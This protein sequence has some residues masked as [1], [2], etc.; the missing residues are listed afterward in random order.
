MPGKLFINYRRQDEPG[1]TQALFLLL[2]AEFGR[3]QL[4]MD[5]Q[6][7]IE[8]GHDFTRVLGARVAACDVVLAVIG[9]RWLEAQDD[10]SRRRL[11]NPDD[12]VRIELTS[13]LSLDKRVIP[14]LVNDAEMPRAQ[15]LPDSLKRISDCQAVNITHERFRPDVQ[16]LV[17]KIRSAFE[18]EAKRNR[19]V[20]L[21]IAALTE[22]WQ[23]ELNSKL[24]QALQTAHLSCNILAPSKNHKL[25]EERF[26]QR[27]VLADADN[28]MGGLAIISGWPDEQIKEL[29]NFADQFQRPVVFIDQN[30]PISEKEIPK[31]V[32]F[33]S[34]RD[35]AGGL[36]AAEAVLQLADQRAVRRILVIAGFAKPNRHETFKQAIRSKLGFDPD[37]SKRGDFNR[38]TS[39]HVV[40]EFLVNGLNENKPFDV[41]FCT[42]DSMTLGCLDAI[43]RIHDWK[44]YLKPRVIGYDGTASTQ[45]L[46][47]RGRSSLACVVVQDT[48]KLAQIAVQQ[49]GKMHIGEHAERI[50]WVEPYLVPSQ[51]NSAVDL[52]PMACNT[53][54]I[55]CT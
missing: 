15:Q 8:P 48:E 7:Y 39:E 9:P 33:V 32:S 16:E 24:L 44:D 12:Y 37:L 17:A 28:Y 1:Y 36:L 51:M 26:L 18:Q 42:S 5:V 3:D 53:T 25:S 4:F 46:A 35:S 49:L 50:A 41:V 23:V 29:L 19:S 2:E 13:A 43:D 31:N 27:Q 40:L 34:V 21:Q 10:Q 52:S 20:F 30:P 55:P 11:D 47:E 6:G 38:E 14:V 45:R 54:N 22:E